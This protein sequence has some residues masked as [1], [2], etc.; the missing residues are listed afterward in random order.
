[1]REYARVDFLIV[2]DF[3]LKSLTQAQADDIAEL[4]SERYLKGGMLFTSSRKEVGNYPRS[5]GR[6]LIAI[7]TDRERNWNRKKD[8]KLHHILGLDHPVSEPGDIHFWSFCAT[9]VEVPSQFRRP[10]FGNLRGKR[11]LLGGMV[12]TR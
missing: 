1:M 6:K 4:A 7:L 11:L 9:C 2:D 10:Y 8:L 3:G 12:L 5:G